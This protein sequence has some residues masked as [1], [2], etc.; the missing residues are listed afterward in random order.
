M[1]IHMF[2][3]A[4]CL[5]AW[6]VASMRP[7][8]D[9]GNERQV[10]ETP[11]ETEKEETELKFKGNEK[12]GIFLW[13]DFLGGKA[14][15]GQ[16]NNGTGNYGAGYVSN[17]D[18][19][20][21]L[22]VDADV[23]AGLWLDVETQNNSYS[24]KFSD[25]P[26]DASLVYVALGVVPLCIVLLLACCAVPC[27]WCRVGRGTALEEPEKAMD[28]QAQEPV[29]R[30][31][32]STLAW[33]I[34][35]PVTRYSLF[36]S[37]VGDLL[38]DTWTYRYAFFKEPLTSGIVVM[39]HVCLAMLKFI[40]PLSVKATEGNPLLEPGM[41]CPTGTTKAMQGHLRRVLFFNTFAFLQLYGYAIVCFFL[42][43]LFIQHWFSVG[44]R[45]VYD[46][47]QFY[48]HNAGPISALLSAGFS[49]TPK[50]LVVICIPYLTVKCQMLARL[51]EAEV[52][53]VCQQLEEVHSVE[54]E[55]KGEG[56]KR[57]KMEQVHEACVRMARDV[58]PKLQCLAGPTLALAIFAW[59]WGLSSALS[60]VLSAIGGSEM[61]GGVSLESLVL[62]VQA[63]RSSR[64]YLSWATAGLSI[65]LT[66][67]ILVPTGVLCLLLPAAVSDAVLSL[68][69]SLNRL[70]SLEGLTDDSEIEL[71]ERFL[72][73][74]NRGQGLGFRVLGTVIT[75]RLIIKTFGTIAGVA[76]PVLSFLAAAL[77]NHQAR[78]QELFDDA[79]GS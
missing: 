37:A 34:E 78:I 6:H 21:V 28:Q 52:R 41:M 49:R 67:L 22:G 55:K 56:I 17:I 51:V 38:V 39:P 26:P 2:A 7:T 60:A 31:K 11:S 76:S 29:P 69:D 50:L 68:L 19:V 23:V 16:W 48:V 44:W 1:S 71:T 57:L 42:T 25:K 20:P 65:C 40:V 73:R 77:R 59:A 75:T 58:L 14:Y 74:F 43:V 61:E 47:K 46:L 54:T 36:A 70:R 27:F 10:T 45:F 9:V 4:W 30:L 12:T 32:A 79:G 66:A 3:T 5:L 8:M 64:Q 13:S 33:I 18:G 53:A 15:A 63:S 62:P 24:V 72:L 35:H